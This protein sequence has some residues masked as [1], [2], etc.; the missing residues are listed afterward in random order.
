MS[1][2]QPCPASTLLAQALS[3]SQPLTKGHAAIA[4]E[5]DALVLVT[6]DPPELLR[7][8][9]L[10]VDPHSGVALDAAERLRVGRWQES[11][12]AHSGNGP[13][14]GR[15][16]CALRHGSRLARLGRWNP[17]APGGGA[18]RRPHPSPGARAGRGPSQPR[19]VPPHTQP[20]PS[21]TSAQVGEG[22]VGL[23]VRVAKVC[24][25]AAHHRV[26]RRQRL[27]I[28]LHL[29]RSRACPAALLYH[30]H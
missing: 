22:V 28:P 17:S 29:A 13:R 2:C 30:G 4:L 25:S 6:L 26:V 19:T 3:P 20:R 12:D 14:C 21:H 9:V 27:V 24:P 8:A 7:G 16:G 15:A 18:Q 23:E 11:V 1:P 5:I 10:R